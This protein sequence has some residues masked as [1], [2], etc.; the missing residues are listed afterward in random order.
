[1]FK[2]NKTIYII[3][4]ILLTSV[5]VI[6]LQMPKS[7]NDTEAWIHEGMRLYEQGKCPEAIAALYHASV[8]G[9]EFAVGLLASVSNSAQCVAISLE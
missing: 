1:M 2:N 8:D 6:L 5:A 4:S 9:D 3:L 7:Q